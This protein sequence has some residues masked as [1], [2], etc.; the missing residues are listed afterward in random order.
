MDAGA[1]PA[2]ADR[3]FLAFDVLSPDGPMTPVS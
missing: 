1:T 2:A 3:G